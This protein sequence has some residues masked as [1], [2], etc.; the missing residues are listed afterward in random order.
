M[1]AAEAAFLT[2]QLIDAALAYEKASKINLESIMLARKALSDA[3]ASIEAVLT[4]KE[5]A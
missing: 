3:R 4:E 2:E 5:K 1:T